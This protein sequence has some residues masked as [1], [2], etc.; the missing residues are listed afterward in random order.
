[1]ALTLIKQR[2]KELFN[3]NKDLAFVFLHWNLR[4][5]FRTTD[6]YEV[7]EIANSVSHIGFIALARGLRWYLQ[8]IFRTS[9][10]FNK[11]FINGNIS[12]WLDSLHTPIAEIYV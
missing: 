12:P 10:A 7:I 2:L 5:F 11:M 8:G 4:D 9:F 3:H 1:V 6:K